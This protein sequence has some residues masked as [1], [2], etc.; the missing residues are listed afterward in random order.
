MKLVIVVVMFL[1]FCP[2]TEASEAEKKCCSHDKNACVYKRSCEDGTKVPK[3]HTPAV[4]KGKDFAPTL[5][6]MSLKKS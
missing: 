6:R 4:V 1:C 3:N 5:V 2:V